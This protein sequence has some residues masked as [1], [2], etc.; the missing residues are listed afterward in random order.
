MVCFFVARKNWTLR[1]SS[2]LEFARTQRAYYLYLLLLIYAKSNMCAFLNNVRVFWVSPPIK[3]QLRNQL[4]FLF[5]AQCS[6]ASLGTGFASSCEQ[7][8]RFSIFAIKKDSVSTISFGADG[9]TCKEQNSFCDGIARTQWSVTRY[10][11]CDL[12]RTKLPVQH[13]CNKKR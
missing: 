7:N 9:R 11:F 4:V 5:A 12:L 6:G 2:S 3:N 1:Q 13:F 8:C 10:R